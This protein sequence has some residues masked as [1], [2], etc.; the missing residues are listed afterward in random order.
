[1]GTLHFRTERTHSTSPLRMLID[2]KFA[3]ATQVVATTATTVD[4]LR[5]D[6]AAQV[7]VPAEKQS[8]LFSGSAAFEVSDL[9]DGDVLRLNLRLLGG[10]KKRKKKVYT[11]PKPRKLAVLSYYQVDSTGKITRLRREC[12]TCGAGVFMANHFN[13]LYCGKCGL[14]F[15]FQGD[16]DAAAASK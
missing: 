1:M 10:G 8:L 4:E 16:E 12:P 5:A 9:E 14:T 2:V 15:Q 13:R 7:G 11:T 6:I 3:G